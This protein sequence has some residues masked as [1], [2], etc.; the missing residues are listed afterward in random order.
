MIQFYSFRLVLNLKRVMKLEIIFVI[1]GL[2]IIAINATPQTNHR[3]KKNLEDIK[4]LSLIHH[5]F[6][7]THLIAKDQFESWGCSVVTVSAAE[8]KLVNNCYNQPHKPI[9]ADFLMSEISD[10]TEYDCLFVASGPHWETLRQGMTALN[11]IER[12]AENGVLISSL[13]VGTVVLADTDATNGINL[14]GM[15]GND[16]FVQQHGAKPCHLARVINDRGVITG[17]PG[18]Y[19]P[20]GSTKAPVTELCYAIVK[21]A[22]GYQYVVDTDV[23][24]TVEPWVN[25]SINVAISDQTD[26]PR[27]V[28]M[29]ASITQVK[30]TVYSVSGNSRMPEMNVKLETNDNGSTWSGSIIDLEPGNYEI[31]LQVI[32]SLSLLEFYINVAGI[33]ETTTTTTDTISSNTTSDGTLLVLVFSFLLISTVSSLRKR[34]A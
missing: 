22:M 20:N 9:M 33:P 18:S 17:G 21:E 8:T 4:I 7:N 34:N 16:Y 27:K 1:L 6:G 28:N 15:P 12:A 10:I 11:F 25:Y 29:S 3:D 14:Q 2:S 13:C 23:L 19:P 31:D 5:G 24:T 32:D 30:A 26:F